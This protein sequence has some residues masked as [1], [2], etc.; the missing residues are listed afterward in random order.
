MKV[1]VNLQLHRLHGP[2]VGGM[3]VVSITQRVSVFEVRAESNSA[4]VPGVR[5]T[6]SI[7]AHLTAQ[8]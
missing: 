7:S 5:T 1:K 3:L 8:T 4:D 2:L 6:T